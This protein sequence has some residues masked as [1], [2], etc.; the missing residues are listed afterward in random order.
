MTEIDWIIIALLGCSTVLGVMRGVLR[1][2]LSI[3]GWVVGV[4]LAI[5]FAGEL[6]EHIPLESVGWIPRVVLAALII[7]VAVVFLCGLLGKILSK[8]LQAA[9][10]TFEDRALGAVFGFIRGIVVACACVFFFGM[11]SSIHESRMW[12]QSVLIGPAESLIDCAVPYLPTW[13]AD[14][15]NSARTK[16]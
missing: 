15:R 7:I 1:E 9:A 5:N 16:A 10:I 6:A 4:M 8:L 11:A 2:V 14:M 12:Q 13:L 3:T